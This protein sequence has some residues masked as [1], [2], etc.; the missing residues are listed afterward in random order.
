M[1]VGMR[2]GGVVVCAW[3]CLCLAPVAQAQ[4][5]GG[6]AVFGF[7]QQPQSAQLSALGGVNMTHWGNDV[8]MVLQSPLLLQERLSGQSSASF[9]AFLAGIQQYGFVSAFTPKASAWNM[10]LGVN[11]LGYGQLN[12]TDPS[13]LSLG[14]FNPRDY[15]LQ[16]SVARSIREKWVWG[17][18][19][20]FLHSQYGPYAATGLALD[21]GWMYSDSS[22]GWRAGLLVKNMGAVLSTYA[23]TENKGELPFD[24]Q[25]GISKKLLSAPLQF[26]MT[27]HGLHRLGK[28]YND[29]SFRFETGD[30]NALQPA[31]FLRKLTE[32]LVLGAQAQVTPFLECSLGYHF[33]RSQAL[34]I[35]QVPNGWS[36]ASLGMGFLFRQLH[37]RYATGFYQQQAFHQFSLNFNWKGEGL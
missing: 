22:S 25:L 13:G 3:V 37:I 6:N 17:T 7:V 33:G 30:P 9:N 29:S 35:Y 27:F 24:L 16:F 5:L 8:G 23:A 20:K 32:H 28:Y 15:A 1:P 4:T 12:Q 18:T 14:S 19:V 36:G 11:Y 10:A 26:S 21:M 34:G 2:F 31:G